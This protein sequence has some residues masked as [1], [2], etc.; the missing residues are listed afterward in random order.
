MNRLRGS[1]VAVFQ[2]VSWFFVITVFTDAANLDDLLSPSVVLHGDINIA[3]SN[4]PPRAE[5]T[6]R[7]S[8]IQH[9]VFVQLD[10]TRFIVDQDSP[11]LAADTVQTTFD[12]LAFLKGMSIRLPHQEIPAELLYLRNHTLLI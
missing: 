11:A 4:V 5:P 7:S 1:R 8:Q 10:V 3:V 9:H 6:P 2:V 12:L